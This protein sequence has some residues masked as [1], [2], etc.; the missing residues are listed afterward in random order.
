MNGERE[1]KET[2]E[3]RAAGRESIGRTILVIEEQPYL[4]A[5]LRQRVDPGIAYVRS[6]APGEVS[7]VWRTCRPWPWLLV[8]ATPDPLPG[9]GELIGSHPIPVHWVGRPPAGLPGIPAVHADWTALVGAL[10]RLR[11]L[12]EPGVNGVRLLRNRGLQAPDGRIVLDV[13]NLEGLLAF[14]AGLALPPNGT[15][16]RAVSAL[17]TEIAA[18]RLP[19][20]LERTGSLLRLG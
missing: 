5:A 2:I 9:L 19:L 18:N 11:T 6:A 1:E 3:A 7:R 8:G 16:E 13:F 14:P 12:A 4:W 10:E 17:E 20:R 15:A